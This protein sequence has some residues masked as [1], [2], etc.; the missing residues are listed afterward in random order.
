MQRLLVQV[1]LILGLDTVTSNQ[2]AGPIVAGG[3]DP[4]PV[5]VGPNNAGNFL[6]NQ[7]QMRAASPNLTDFQSIM[8]QAQFASSS[9]WSNP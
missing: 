5:Q 8:D 3:L 1:Y 2:V 4:G 9:C 7:A 6:T